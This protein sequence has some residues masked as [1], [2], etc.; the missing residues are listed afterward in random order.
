MISL[1]HLGILLSFLVLSYSSVKAQSTYL[2]INSFTNYHIDRLDISGYPFNNTTSLKPISRN[3]FYYLKISII[4]SSSTTDSFL[5]KNPIRYFE[6]ELFEYPLYL[7]T[8]KL[9]QILLE[10]D[11]KYYDAWESF[12]LSIYKFPSALFSK[13]TENFN[14]SINPILGFSGGKDLN[15]SISTFQNTRGIEVRGSI[16]NKVGFYSYITEN[17]FR[18]PSY[19]NQII[20]STGVIPG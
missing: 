5:L 11:R 3:K 2:P 8:L 16:D 12:K 7:D 15:D 13:K 14:L 4:N 6:N 1:R 9:G 18:F 17:Q 20:D 10:R 19:Y